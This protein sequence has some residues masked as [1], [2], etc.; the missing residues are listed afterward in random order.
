[1][2]KVTAEDPTKVII[3][4]TCRPDG[5]ADQV[6]LAGDFNGWSL[7]AEPMLR[8]DDGGFWLERQ[9][10]A[11]EEHRYRFVVDDDRWE[12]DPEA[13]ATEA[14]GYGGFNSVVRTGDP[15]E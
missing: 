8:D 12:T 4:F 2:H 7:D 3:T 5:G 15:G 13:D 10:D 1:M 6:V 9:L 11:G 14:D